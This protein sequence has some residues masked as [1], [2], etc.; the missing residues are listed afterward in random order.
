LAPRERVLIGGESGSGKTY[1]WLSIARYNP[2]SQF[3]VAEADDGVT[4]VLSL[5]YPDVLANG[6][7]HGVRNENGIWQPPDLIQE[8]VDFRHFVET[9]KEFKESGQLKE[10]DWIIVE[11]IDLIKNTITYNYIDKVYKIDR[12]TKRAITDPWD[13]I[14]AQ[15][16][17]GSP[18]LDPSD[19]DA[20]N[21]EYEAQLTWPAY[22]SQCNLVGTAAISR[23]NFDSDYADKGVKEYYASLGTPLR[24]DGHKRSPRMFDTLIY[25]FAGNTYQMQILKDRGIGRQISLVDTGEFYLSL[26]KFRTTT[27]SARSLGVS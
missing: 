3:Y 18:I 14:I 5:E 22:I 2:Q 13:A 11:G 7:V 6:N 17:R 21:S 24:I 15:R 8:W 26:E 25:L 9:L 20:I 23:I 4:K 12:K 1:A 10:S 27:M 19:R 16:S